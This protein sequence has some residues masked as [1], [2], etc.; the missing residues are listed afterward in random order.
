[1][2][3]SIKIRLISISVVIVLVAIAA[4]TLISYRMARTFILE[5]INVELGNTAKSNS[6]RLGLW[7]KMQKDIVSSLAPLA[8]SADPSAP[9]QQALESGKLEL[10]YVGYADKRM[11][12]FPSRVRPPEYDPTA[13][14]WYKLADGAG[15]PVITEPYIASSSKKLVVTFAFAVKDGPTTTAVTGADV[16]LEDV[17]ADLQKIK[18]T[19]NGFAFLVNK[20]G[21]IIAHPKSELTLKPLADLSKELT[22]DVIEQASKEADPPA[23]ATIDGHKF[24]LKSSNVEGSDWILVTAAKQSEALER[25]NQLLVSAAMALVVVG[26]VATV[27]STTMVNTQLKGLSSVRDA[28]REIGSGSGDLTQRLPIEGGG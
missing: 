25:L 8:K 14:P 24:L 12:S 6:Q 5:D 28:M 9:L 7:I 27:V 2:F 21:N 20:S 4:S 3:K 19:P 11:I 15:K 17:L 1:M 18:P 13:R 23:V 16:T 22:S 26:L 10:A